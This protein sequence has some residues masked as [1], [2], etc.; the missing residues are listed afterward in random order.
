MFSNYKLIIGQPFAYLHAI[1][2]P[3]FAKMCKDIRALY[4]REKC[5]YSTSKWNIDLRSK[6]DQYDL[7]VPLSVGD[8]ESYDD[9]LHEDYFLHF[10]NSGDVEDYLVCKNECNPKEDI[11]EVFRDSV[12]ECLYECNKNSEYEDPSIDEMLE[13]I[14]DSSSFPMPKLGSLK[15]ITLKGAIKE[16]V[17]ENPRDFWKFLKLKNLTFRRKVVPVSPANERDSWIMHVETFLFVR[18]FERYMKYLCEGHKWNLILPEKDM[19]SKIE[20]FRDEF[21]Y[22]YKVMM[23]QR[24]GGLNIPHYLIKIV[25]QEIDKIDSKINIMRLYNALIN[26]N[27]YLDGGEILKPVRGHGLGIL[28]YMY[29]FVHMSIVTSLGVPGALIFHDD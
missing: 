2:S 23:D 7:P 5:S 17:N 1:S 18:Y 8:F 4:I 29:S 27:V 20:K 3:Y 28:F 6:L 9:V 13:N 10:D 22:H 25:C 15:S 21:E 24:K 12:K 16:Y 19:N 11:Q 14:S 26:S